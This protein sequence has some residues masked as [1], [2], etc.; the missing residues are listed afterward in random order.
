[1]A[2]RILVIQFRL[3]DQARAEQQPLE[4]VLGS[5][6]CSLVFK[7][8]FVEGIDWSRPERELHGFDAV[9]LSGSG[10]LYFDGG[11]AETHHG[12]IITSRLAENAK[13]F[14]QYLIE[15]NIPTL[16]IC[17]GHQL[18]G[19]AAGVN[20]GHSRIESKTGTYGVRLTD[21]GRTDPLMKDI[22]DRFAAHYGHKDVLFDLP[23]GA[24]VLAHGED[25]CRYSAL[26]Y[27]P[28]VYSVQF[29]PEL[30]RKEIEN[31][32]RKYPEYMPDDKDCDE[33]FEDTEEAEHILKNFVRVATR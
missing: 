12:R 4:R 23:P 20:V 30:S 19:Y 17:F 6:K 26:R 32:M 31:I 8:A 28:R 25:K 13:P 9:I 24:V 14:A 21:I 22:S 27:A 7:N 16:G 29:H 3:R 15:N 5:E 11:Y 18:L 1:M 10:D 2:A 33:L